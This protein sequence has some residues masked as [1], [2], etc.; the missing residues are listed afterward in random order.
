MTSYSVPPQPATG[1][2]AEVTAGDT[3]P[4]LAPSLP[5]EDSQGNALPMMEQVFE[6]APQGMVIVDARTLQIKLANR[7]ARELY[8]RHTHDVGASLDGKRL[9]DLLPWLE[10]RG[11]LAQ[12][13]QVSQSGTPALSQVLEVAGNNSSGE[14]GT[15]W[16]Y[17]LVPLGAAE[18]CIDDLLVSVRDAASYHWERKRAE[19]AI[20]AAQQRTE[21]LE[22]IF[23]QIAEAVVVRDRDG[24]LIVYNREALTLARNQASVER[25]RSHGGRVIPDWEI[26]DSGGNPL[27][28][29]E[30]PE[31]RVMLTGKSLLSDQLLVRK[32]DGG[33]TPL[34]IHATPLRDEI[35]DITGAVLAFQDISVVKEEERLKDE[36]TSVASHELR[37]PITVIQGHAQR[38]KRQL[39]QI[40]QQ[41]QVLI[42]PEAL[43]K[44]ADG[45]E[46][47]T[48]RLNRLV[49]DLLDVSRIQAGHLQL[50][51][52]PMSLI[53]LVERLVEAQRETNSD[54]QF[55]VEDSVPSQ[56]AGLTGTW[57]ESRVEQILAN[58]LQN[59]V[60]YSPAGGEIRITLN[61]LPRGTRAGS[62]ERGRKRLAT[63][64]AHAAITDQGI[65]VPTGGLAHLFERFYR[66]PNTNDIQGTGLG[67]YICQQL[68]MAHHGFL[69][70]ESR[71]LGHGSTFHLVLPL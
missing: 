68:A 47:Q 69:W 6:R 18:G 5:R 40:T 4:A 65:G 12:L 23:E 34:L 22:S 26:V 44:L 32:E 14:M 64:S 59:A 2:D 50:H 57:D 28:R 43:R 60:K 3:P 71:G 38:L 29:S 10:S 20:F 42:D 62:R 45:M 33:V 1:P 24:R 52:E 30:L 70:A 36:M 25:A 21:M 55:V 35:G 56:Y 19:A 58:L 41:E 54:H 51:A 67:L 61:V 7:M 46:S 39:R 48:T 31:W 8:Q 27:P 63:D 53:Q 15:Y 11:L 9:D 17:D 13:R 66:A 49:S 16:N 37:Q